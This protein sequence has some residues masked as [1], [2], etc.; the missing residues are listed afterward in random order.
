MFKDLTVLFVKYGVRKGSYSLHEEQFFIF[1]I[2]HAVSQ[3]IFQK[4]DGKKSGF[5]NCAWFMIK[6]F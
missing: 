1:V 2:K 3:F 6:N 4:K 5:I